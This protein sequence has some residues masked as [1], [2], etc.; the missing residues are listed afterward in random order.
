MKDNQVKRSINYRM[1]IITT[2]LLTLIVML[3]GCGGANDSPETTG[4]VVIGITDAEGDF[5][6]YSINVTGLTLTKASGVVVNVLPGESTIDFAQLTEMTEFFTVATIPSGIYTHATMTLDYSNA[7][8]QVEDASGSPLAI[9]TIVDSQN[10]PVTTWE[11]DVKLQ[12][13]NALLIAPGVPAHLTLDYDL[14]ASNSVD[15]STATV[16]LS[17]TLLADI[18]L[19]DPKP[20]R[21]R[22]FLTAVDESSDKITLGIRPF[23]RRVGN[24]GRLNAYVD[25]QTAYEIDGQ[26]Y[27]GG[28]GLATLALKDPA[29]WIVVYGA[30]NTTTHHF[31]ATEVYAGSSVPG[32][33]KDLITGVVLARSGN[34]LTVNAGSIVRTDGSLVFNKD[35]TVT[36]SDTTLVNR[37]LSTASFTSSDISIGQRLALLGT[38]DSGADNML[39]PDLAR[40]LMNQVSGNVVS[41]NGS[42]MVVNL[43]AINGRL[44]A[45]YDFS[46]TGTSS[47]DDT[48]PAN[49]QVD[50]GSLSVGAQ[51]SDPVKVRGFTTAF[52]SAPMDYTATTVIEVSQLPANM[53]VTWH[54]ANT[55]AVDDLIDRSLSLDLTYSGLLQFHHVWRGWVA[56]DLTGLGSAPK[57]TSN[58]NDTGLFAI[59]QAGSIFVYFNFS[60]FETALDE[61]LDSGSYLVKHVTASGPFDDDTATLTARSATVR[62]WVSE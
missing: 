21:V 51:V 61:M 19:A 55:T 17:P 1:Y 37:Q 7:D 50:L 52:G 9:T 60:A 12:D 24:F 16:T 35:V 32:A 42:E 18:Q 58:E 57:I 27:I 46:G 34:V 29:T 2:L 11:V 22:G 13:S 39:N 23:F 30:L 41:V 40:M 26:S 53:L 25:D 47:G 38:L 15:I 5:L 33:D 56:T 28:I 59:N 3:N 6:N 43:Q 54:P 44:V 10:N 62:L 49:Y 20:H 48:D 45:R 4:D 14:E 8:I 31:E 36:L